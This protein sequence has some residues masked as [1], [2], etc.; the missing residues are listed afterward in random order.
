MVLIEPEFEIDKRNRVICKFHSDYIQFIDPNKD[1]FEDIYLDKNLT[2]LTCTHYVYN[3]CYFN[4][5][6]IDHI[7]N[8]RQ[9]KRDF[10]CQLCRNRIER[11][12]TIIYKLYNEEVYGIKIPLICCSCYDKLR[13]NQ[14]LPELKKLNLFYLF[15]I[16][17]TIFFLFYLNFFLMLLNLHPLIRLLIFISYFCLT[18]AIIF[19]SLMRLK[20]NLSGIK[21]YKKMFPK[22]MTPE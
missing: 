9:K 19:I 8:T 6:R 16:L 4:K 13:D 17:T 22:E 15:I 18:I 14:Y 12:F 11:M 7:E 5:S 21:T 3:E 20:T 1:Y 2:C 10:K